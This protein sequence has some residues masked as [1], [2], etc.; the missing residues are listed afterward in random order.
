MTKKNLVTIITDNRLVA[1]TIA[2]VVGATHDKESHY[3]GNGY[4]VTWTNGTIIEATFKPAEKFVLSS[5]QDMRQMYA[6]LENPERSD[7]VR[8]VLIDPLKL[9]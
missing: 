5:G 2:K 1:D 9:F 4:A 6:H 3:L 7:P 8:Q